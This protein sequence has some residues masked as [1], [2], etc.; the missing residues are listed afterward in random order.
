MKLTVNGKMS[1]AN[2]N[3]SVIALLKEKNVE[4]PDMVSVEINGKIIRKEKYSQIELRE[5]D[6][7]EFL[8]FMGGG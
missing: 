4:S 1:E 3:I 6:R 7:V 5:N 8:Y 2:P